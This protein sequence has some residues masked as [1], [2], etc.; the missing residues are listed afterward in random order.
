MDFA[1]LRITAPS[2]DGSEILEMEVIIVMPEATKRGN[3]EFS[4]C[5]LFQE[6]QGREGHCGLSREKTS[7]NGDILYCERLDTLR[8]YVLQKIEKND[9]L[10]QP[11]F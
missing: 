9:I 8:D 3:S 4:N 6:S 5:R 11:G 1:G 2:G 7:C 10:G